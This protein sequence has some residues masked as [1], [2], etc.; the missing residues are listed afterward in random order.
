MC[1]ILQQMQQQLTEI[2]LSIQISIQ[3]ANN[4]SVT[5]QEMQSWLLCVQGWYIYYNL[6][7]KTQTNLNNF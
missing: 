1:E 2:P 3:N 6:F 4:I 7:E 5:W